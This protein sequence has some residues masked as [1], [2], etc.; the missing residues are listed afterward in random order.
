MFSMLFWRDSNKRSG[1][2]Q[3]ALQPASAPL[4]CGPAALHPVDA[5]VAPYVVTH[6]FHGVVALMAV[7]RPIAGL[8]GDKTKASH[9]PEG[10]H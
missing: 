8:V 5:D 3:V 1:P 2:S 4:G 9:C 6:G 10:A 7:D